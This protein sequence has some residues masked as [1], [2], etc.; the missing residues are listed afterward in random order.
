MCA[1]TT[2][3]IRDFECEHAAHTTRLKYAIKDIA[4]RVE[5]MSESE[6]AEAW[7][8]LL[9]LRNT[10][11]SS[12]CVI[13]LD[14]SILSQ[15]S[16]SQ[17]RQ[18]RAEVEAPLFALKMLLGLEGLT[19]RNFGLLYG[20]FRQLFR[21]RR[22]FRL[23]GATALRRVHYANCATSTD[24]LRRLAA[25]DYA[26]KKEALAILNALQVRM[27]TEARSASTAQQEGLLQPV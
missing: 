1:N 27:K 9:H 12:L 8:E 19:E 17:K 3:C 25:G 22:P 11:L 2:D 10:W 24:C 7:Q 4:S 23:H 15:L 13:S 6:Q 20:E 18:M 26:D 14:D 5:A 16:E 21:C